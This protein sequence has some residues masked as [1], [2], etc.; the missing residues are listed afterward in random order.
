M[1]NNNNNYYYN[2]IKLPKE[3][4]VF[5]KLYPNN[6]MEKGQ[7]EFNV[8]EKY[9][10]SK[11]KNCIDIGAHV[12][13]TSIRHAQYF[14]NVYSFEPVHYELLK[15]N[16]KGFPTI[17]CYPYAVSDKEQI[18]EIYPGT[19]NSGVGI[20]PTKYNK[21]FIYNRFKKPNARYKDVN[22]I[23]VECKTIDSFEF[24][25][26]TFIKIDVEGYNIP[27]IN[28]MLETLKKYK[29]IIQLEEAYEKE[30]NEAVRAILFKLGYTIREKFERDIFLTTTTP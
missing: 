21:K 24:E 12:G 19:L 14:K 26:I 23:Q 25:E 10:P 2:T 11:R 22:T 9:F 17:H 5:Q 13:I 16:T 6:P 30:V 15:E 28:G 20:I 7:K 1:N 4:I 8:V 18:I 3:D 29:P 27:V